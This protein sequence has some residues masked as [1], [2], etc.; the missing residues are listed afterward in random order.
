MIASEQSRPE[1]VRARELFFTE[2]LKDVPLQDIVVLDESYATTSFTR[3]RGRSVRN[4]RLKASVPHGHWKTLTMIAA[5]TIGGVL[6]ATT[7]DAATNTEVFR[8]FVQEALV[9]TLR[10]GMVVVMDNLAAHKVTG[11]REAIESAGCQLLYLPPYSPDMSPIEHVWS[12][13]KQKLRTTAARDIP[14]LIT[15]IGDAL[16]SVTPQDC[17]NCFLSCGYPLRLR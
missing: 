8:A 5:I 11:I 10:P 6:T 16:I 4:K 3:L 2:Q 7:I 13:V 9:P 12:Q 1:V 14:R 15:A 17:L